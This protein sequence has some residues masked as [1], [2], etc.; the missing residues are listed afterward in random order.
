MAVKTADNKTIPIIKK[1]YYF[2][3]ARNVLNFKSFSITCFKPVIIITNSFLYVRK[4]VLFLRI[5]RQLKNK[6]DFNTQSCA[7]HN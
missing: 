3:Y 7:H 2:A 6:K 4:T 1:P 5:L